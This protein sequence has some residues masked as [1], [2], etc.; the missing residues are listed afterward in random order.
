[1]YVQRKRGR[2]SFWGL[3]SCNYGA[4]DVPRVTW[5][6]SHLETPEN[7]GFS[8]EARVWRLRSSRQWCRSRL[9]ARGPKIQEE[10]KLLCLSPKAA[11]KLTSQ[12]EGSQA[13]TFPFTWV[14]RGSLGHPFCSTQASTNWMR[15]T[16][17][18]GAIC[19]TQ[20]FNFVPKHLHGNPQNNAWPK[21]WATCVWPSQTDM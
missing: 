4:Q 1:M 9:K 17:T 14:E 12:F 16:H 3:G 8:S 6:V 5:W 19:L 10:L 11:Q 15:L 20:S 2:V 18:R 13:W 21:I 7:L